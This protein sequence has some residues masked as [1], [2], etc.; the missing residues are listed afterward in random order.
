MVPNPFF[1]KIAAEL[2]LWK[3]VAQDLG[4]FCNFERNCLPRVKNCPKGENSP[5][6]V[7]LHRIQSV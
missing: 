4:Y 6:L 3:I 7:T 2:L 1:A 5:N